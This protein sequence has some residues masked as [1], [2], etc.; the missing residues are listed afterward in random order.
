LGQLFCNGKSKEI[1]DLLLSEL[2]EVNVPL[3]LN[4]DVES[5]NY[6]GDVFRVVTS[7]GVIKSRSLVIAT[8]G[9]SI[10][11][12]GATGIGYELA[13]QFGHTLLPRR[14]G[15]V[16]FT[17]TDKHKDMFSN[18][19]GASISV[20]ISCHGHSFAEDMLFTHRGLSGP[21]VLQISSYWRAGDVISVDLLPSLNAGQWL[22]D[23]KRLNPKKSFARLFGQHWPKSIATALSEYFECDG[24]VGEIADK[25]LLA[26]GEQLNDWQ[27]KPSGTEGYRTAEVTLG[28]VNTNELSSKSM[29]SRK[30]KDLYFIGE[31]V[32]VTGHLGGFNFQWAWSS[33]YVCADA[34]SQKLGSTP[35]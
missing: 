14:A 6:D 18:L 9:L 32:D 17:F 7:K 4:T 25:S 13:E 33:A 22:L 20:S 3:T 31:V 29:E 15:L 11:T 10:P 34:I 23:E 19:S 21:A 2:E 8:G 28:G 24:L 5:V 30:Q 16:P 26:L 12:M 1:L 27:V 35:D